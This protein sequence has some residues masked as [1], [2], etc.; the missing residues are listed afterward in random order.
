MVNLVFNAIDALSAGGQIVLRTGAEAGGGWIE[1]SDTGPGMPE[2]VEKRVFEP[3]FTTKAQGT[4]LGLAMVYAFA[5]RHAGSITVET[6]LG[7]GTKFR[8]WFPRLPTVAVEGR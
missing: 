8:L 6:K 2:E 1:V 3:F 4:G 7:A 5:K